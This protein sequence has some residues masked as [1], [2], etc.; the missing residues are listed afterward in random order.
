MKCP[1][2]RSENRDTAKFCENCGHR[3]VVVCPNCGESNRPGA[4]F[5]D[6]CGYNLSKGQETQAAHVPL[7]PPSARIPPKEPIA[8][9]NTADTIE[10]E[11]RVVT[12]LFCDVTGSTQAA[13]LLDPEDWTEIMNGVFERM[14]QP[15]STYQG[16]VARLMGDAVLAF[17]GAPAAHEDDPQRAVLA[18]LEIVAGM[19]DYRTQLIHEW[20]IAID[21][22]VGINTGLVVVGKVGADSRTEYTAMG[23]AVNLAA[24][25]EQTA[26]PGTVQVSEDTY[27]LVAP[28]FDFEPLG[29]QQVKGKADPVNTYRPLRRKATTG[30][31]RGIA[32]LDAPLIGRERERGVLEGA[33]GNLGKGIGGILCL[34]GEAGL[35]KSRLL[36]EV[37]RSSQ[38]RSELQ[39][40]ET[41]SLSYETEQPYALFR[42]L[43]RRVIG[44]TAE[45]GQDVIRHKIQQATEAVPFEERTQVE[46]VFESMLGLASAKGE[47]PLEGETFKGLLYTTMMAWWQQ[48]TQIGPVVLVCDD[49]H[50][51]DPASV[52]L[53]Q[54]L[55]SLTDRSAFLLVF[56]MRQ[57]PDAPGWQAMQVAASD[58]PHRYSEIRLQT[59]S[60]DESGELVDSLLR[61]SDLPPDLRARIM[62]KSEGNP[63]FIEEVVRTL[64]DQGL[65]LQD[66]S[67]AH[68]HAV[69]DGGDF[70]IPSNLQ[71]LLVARMDRLEEEARR[72]LQVASVVGR[73]FYYRILQRLIDFA[74]HDLDQHLLSLQRTQLIKEA[75][76]LPELEYMFRHALT[77]DAAYSTILLKQRRAFHRRVGEALENLFPDQLEEL[78]PQLAV[79]FA[80]SRQASK[81]LAY[82]TLAGETA[83]R[84]FAVNEALTHYDQAMKWAEP[85]GATVQQLIHL[86]QR[87]GRALELLLR[88]DEALETYQTL[89]ALG[90]TRADDSMRLAGISAQVLEYWFGH[91]QYEKA[92]L[93]AEEALALARELGDRYTEARSLWSLLLSYTWDDSVQSLTYGEN[94]LA[95]AR[96]LVSGPDSSNEDLE[97]LALILM[98]LT[99]PLV[100]TGQVK[101]AREYA[102]EAQLLFQKLGNLPLA[103]TAGQRLGIAYKM[104]GQFQRS[105]EVTDHSMAIDR[106]M[107]NEGGIVGGAIG[108]LDLYLDTG[109]YAKFFA[110]LDEIIPLVIR[111]GR[112]PVTVL[113]LYPVAVYGHL[114]AIDQVQQM[115]DPILQFKETGM[116][117]Y[118]SWFLAYAAHAL[119]QAGQVEKAKELLEKIE[120]DFDAK[121]YLIPFAPLLPQIWAELA[122]ATG[123]LDEALAEV[124]D[125]LDGVRQT[126]VLR[127]LPEKLLLKGRILR[128]ANRPEEAYATWKEAHALATEQNTRP[129]LWRICCHLAAMEAERGNLTQVQVLKEQARPV[130]DYI[131]DHAG[132]DDLRA[133]FL[134]IPMVQ[135]IL[136]DTGENHVNT[137]PNTD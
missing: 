23:D 121:S 28:L 15:I 116:I 6:N 119:I 50:W 2:C 48:Q 39:W 11:R 137:I 62:D 68:W 93:R 86:H 34:I 92:R 129:H 96:D 136:S 36:Q 8:N 97:L 46:R 131:A 124:D 133:S 85:G 13:E 51:S 132:R 54:R 122:L 103:A 7:Q 56:A 16:L 3:L 65:V 9:F 109:D 105:E 91:S 104:E 42:R 52:A 58:F 22:R 88:H 38:D 123:A 70:D 27:R 63:Y 4:R 32:G 64:I 17:F 37:K 33:I 21:V 101:A 106:S 12:V 25:M 26:A 87:R 112:F 43:I 24:R 128:K 74:M 71:T 120:T 18:G 77:Q 126:E 76:R 29:E 102:L 82:Y 19:S 20:G 127:Y 45:E 114:G 95:I 69:G 59:L 81:A 80:E 66:E 111:E 35:G 57:E 100:A 14:I 79:H 115:I 134:A 118:P 75:A 78:A 40:I 30:R 31:L 61:I 117:I 125:F 55:F 67:G 73:S 83:L 84:M 90:E 108:L 60:A 130:I 135:T 94:G 107:G 113:E 98:D 110:L 47:P 41:F 99:L 44:A 1:N 49:L 53:L 89:E 72:I 5:C 10:G